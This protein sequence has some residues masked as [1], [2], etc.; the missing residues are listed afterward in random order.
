MA[1]IESPLKHNSIEKKC[2]ISTKAAKF[3]EAMSNWYTVHSNEKGKIPKSLL[4]LNSQ[5]F[6]KF[7]CLLAH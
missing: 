3:H 1:D 5:N 2:F 4:E 7:F 6:L